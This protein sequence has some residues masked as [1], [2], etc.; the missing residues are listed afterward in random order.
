MK[1]LDSFGLYTLFV[2]LDH[3]ALTD[4]MYRTFPV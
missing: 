2:F 3:V 4:G 1:T